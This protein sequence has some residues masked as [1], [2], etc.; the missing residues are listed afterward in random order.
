[1]NYKNIIQMKVTEEQTQ[2]IKKS[3]REIGLP[4]TSFCRFII[5]KQLK[6]ENSK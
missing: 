2:K 4:M 5:L 3:A 1:M 6:E